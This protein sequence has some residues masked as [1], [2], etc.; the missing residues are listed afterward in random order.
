M[1]ASGCEAVGASEDFGPRSLRGGRWRGSWHRGAIIRSGIKR[2]K[3]VE[4]RVAKL[5]LWTFE[6]GGTCAVEV[7]CQP[8]LG[9]SFG[10]ESI[11]TAASTSP[12]FAEPNAA[13]SSA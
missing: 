9:S 6:V 4:E 8:G 7:R 10:L 11:H 3:V 1:I 5:I 13:W 2:R 12:T